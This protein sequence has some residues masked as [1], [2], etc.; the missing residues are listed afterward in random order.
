MKC[1]RLCRIL[2]LF[3]ALTAGIGGFAPY[4][5]K[6]KAAEPPPAP[7]SRLSGPET[8]DVSSRFA[9]FGQP[10][11]LDR[12]AI[13][14]AFASVAN[15]LR[16]AR[17]V[18]VPG[19][20]TDGLQLTNRAGITDYLASQIAAL[21][22]EGFS[23]ALAPVDTEARVTANAAVL[24]R[25]VGDDDRP[26][27]FVS[28]SKGGVDVLQFLV[29]ADAQT[30]AGIACWLALQAPFHGSPIADLAAGSMP[31]RAVADPLAGWLGGDPGSLDDLTVGVRAPWMAD[32]DGTIRAIVAAIPTLAVATR[33]DTADLDTPNFYMRPAWQWMTAR[34]QPN[35]GLVP[36]ASAV[37]PGARHLVLNGLDHTDTVAN[38]AV[39]DRAADRLLF[40]KALLALTLGEN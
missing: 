10:G 1:R 11:A 6:A 31:L 23:V 17:I 9:A 38:N 26:V 18:V 39:L 30:R 4:A 32:R 16:G 21:R 20:L 24:A 7:L 35:D 14:A 40:L 15:D 36:V 5:T 13:E 19:H 37:L 33:V 29:N 22:A 8:R 34:D 28:H 3:A 27:C 12:D 25:L 2:P